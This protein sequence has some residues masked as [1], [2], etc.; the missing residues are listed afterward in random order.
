MGRKSKP[1]HQGNNITFL[2]SNS[3]TSPL[4]HRVGQG[5][6]FV[7]TDFFKVFQGVDLFFWHVDKHK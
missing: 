3:N 6:N 4:R 5:N 1:D 2:Q 7:G